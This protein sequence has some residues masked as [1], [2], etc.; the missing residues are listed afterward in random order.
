MTEGSNDPAYG[1][2]MLAV[3]VIL[4]AISIRLLPIL[5]NT[6]VQLAWQILPSV[7]IIML[8]VGVIRAMIRKLLE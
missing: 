4:G 7:L 5:L 3:A 6:L 8:I 2:A 1:V